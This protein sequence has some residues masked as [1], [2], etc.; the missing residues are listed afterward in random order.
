MTDESRELTI[1]ND[2]CTSSKMHLAGDRLLGSD[3]L[4]QWPVA[5]ETSSASP[6]QQK[7]EIEEMLLNEDPSISNTANKI[8]ELQVRD[9]FSLEK[10]NLLL[11]MILT[12]SVY[13]Q[14]RFRDQGIE[15][16]ILGKI[17]DLD[18]LLGVNGL[19][20]IF[21]NAAI[22]N[23][24]SDVNA[25]TMCL[26]RNV[27]ALA[28][29]SPRFEGDP[30]D[31]ESLNVIRMEIVRVMCA[32]KVIETDGLQ[33]CSVDD[34]YENFFQECQKGKISTREWGDYD[35]S[36]YD[37][38]QVMFRKHSY[39]MAEKAYRQVLTI[40]KSILGI[41]HSLAIECERCV[42]ECLSKQGRAEP[43]Q[44]EADSNLENGDDPTI[45]V[46]D[47]RA[48]QERL[49][50]ES[51]KDNKKK[52]SGLIAITTPKKLPRIPERVFI[53][54]ERIGAEQPNFAEVTEL[55][56]NSL[57]AQAISGRPAQ[58]PPL[59]LV[60]PPGVGKTRYIKRI[61]TVLG[62]PF[63]D[64]QLAGVT[65][66]YR[67]AGLSRYWGTAGP[68]AI[69]NMFVDHGVANPVFLLDEIDKAKSDE[70]G[71]PLAVIML[72]LETESSRTFKDAFV[73]VPIDVSHA[74][75]IATANN[76]SNLPEPLISRFHCIEVA[77]LDYDGRSTMVKTTYAELL[78]QENLHGFLDQ[79]V[80]KDVLE[81]L[82]RCELLNGRE[83]K[84]EIQLAMHRA[85]REHKYGLQS[86]R[87][88]ILSPVH[89]RLPDNRATRSIGFLN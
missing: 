61:S 13:L 60:G 75:F 36:A 48:F 53:E 49:K 24:Q 25:L 76:T 16:T 37:Y 23:L 84:R 34:L 88:I 22:Q 73:D 72:L 6:L 29:V 14:D 89:L 21:I 82:A 51:E 32:L 20:E 30:F 87:S 78:E 67:I 55:V 79:E 27:N 80:S 66:A 50:Q 31:F 40:R 59:L 77:P 52:L 18:E 70:K 43:A 68:G 3:V 65:E 44:L 19:L 56:V 28:N 85:C 5:D 2:R 62:L 86:V 64:I 47:E 71:D 35:V 33:V 81:A 9:K 7:T 12:L 63:Q 58:L 69:A 4:T 74:S 54:I 83:L 46:C 1:Q 39:A 10:D 38:A 17:L 42:A 15:Y 8:T 41:E 26:V 45:S 11:E 57:H